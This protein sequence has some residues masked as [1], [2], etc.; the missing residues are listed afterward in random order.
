[1]NRNEI[2]ELMSKGLF[3]GKPIKGKLEE[4][5]ISWVLLGHK[6]VFKIKKPVKLSFL[7]YST[8]ELRKHNCEKELELNKRFSPI[9]LSV[10]PISKST[11]NWIIGD[12]QHEIVDYAVC[13]LK[14]D[15]NKRMDLLLEKNQV[16]ANQIIALAKQVAQ[17]HINASVIH[18]KIELDS[19][20]GIFNDVLSVSELAGQHLD[21][22]YPL[23]ISSLVNW[24]NEFIRSNLESLKKRVEAKFIRDVHGDLHSRNI[25]LYKEPIIFDCIEFE[26]SF[27]QIDVLYEVAFI[28][29]DLES[30]GRKDFADRFL[31]TYLESYDCM[32][33]IEDK[34]IFQY[35][36]CLRANIRAKVF[37]LDAG[38][39]PDSNKRIKKL[40]SGKV[41]LDLA[42]F[43]KV[44]ANPTLSTLKRS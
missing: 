29:M 30:F 1:M 38:S 3:A 24:S 2:L 21:Q 5:N 34:K 33:S 10:L 15:S 32:P 6:Y 9:Y 36:K 13:M 26:E 11:D 25:F 14:M 39:E 23:Q 7:D 42:Y 41:Y 31:E 28:C 44:S 16:S 27:R 12:T 40:E 43:Y 18:K 19:M 37:L 4:T 35:Y 20:S 22:K 8:L 17:F